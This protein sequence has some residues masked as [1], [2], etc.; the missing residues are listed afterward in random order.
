[1]QAGSSPAARANNTPT[2]PRKALMRITMLQKISGAIDGIEWP[3]VGGVIDI[4]EDE[5]RRLIHAGHAEVAADVESVEAA[6]VAD[7]KTVETA[8]V[9]AAVETATVEAPVSTPA[10]N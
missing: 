1:M 2:F 7:V 5:A 6:V 8:A 4:I 10:A 9:S 3:N